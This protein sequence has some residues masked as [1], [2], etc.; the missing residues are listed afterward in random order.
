[1]ALYQP[2]NIFPSSFAGVGGGV[3][4]VTQPLTVSW[5]VNGSS[6]MTA[7]QIKIYENTTASKLVYNS[8]RVNL[9]H[10]FYGM[11]STGDVNY[12]QVTIPA[13]RLIN[14]SNG[15]SSGYK[16][17]IT[18]WWNGGSIQQLSPSFFLTRTNPAVTVSVPATVTSRSVTFTG[19]YTQAQGDTLDWFRWELALQDDPESPIEDSGYIYG[20][21]DIQVTY[22]G[23]F[24]NT[25][26][27]VRLTIQTENGVQ[28]TTGWQNFTAQYDVSDMKGYVDACVSPLEGVIIQWPRISY[29]NGKPSGPHQLTGGQLRLPAGSSITWDERNGEPMNI[30]T[31]WSLAWSGIVPL[32]GTSPVWRITGDGHT[33][34]LSIEP[35]LISL[36]LDGAV[37]ASVEIP[38]LLVDYTIRMVLT[39]R[40]LHMY[41]PVQEGGLYPSSV[42]F[43]SA[44]LYPMGGDV[45]WERFTYPLT[46]VQ[47]DIE[48]ITLYGEQRCDYIMVSGGEVSGALLGDLLTNFEFEPSWTLDTWFLATF[49]GTGINGGNITPSGDSITGAAVYRLKKGDRRLQLVANVGIGSSTLVDEGFRNQST[50]TYYVFVLGTNTYVSAPLISNPVT[51]M[52]WNWTVLDCS[53]DSNGTYH[54]EEAHLFRNSVSTDSISNNNAP[55]MLQN[56]TP[57]PL[58]QPSSYN[59]KSSTLT[60]YIGRVDMKL[61]QYI[62]TVDMAEALYNLSVSNNPKFLRDRKG[63]LWRIQT[64]AAVSMQTGDTMVPQPYFGSFPWAEVGAADGISII[65]QPGDGAWDSTTGQEPDSGETVTKIVVT[66]PF[67]STVTL[68]NGQESYTEVCYGYITYQPATPGDWT[69]TAMRDGSSA[70]ETITMAEGVTYYV[71]LVITEVYA[72]LII[73][74]PS[75]TVITVSQG[76]EFEETKVV[77]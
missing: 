42:L 15:F 44:T 56:F 70:S 36:I 50:Y 6:A 62:D 66:A 26:Y 45:S 10:P 73:A 72:T 63:N 22:D 39:P 11:T 41:Y 40:E 59:F 27:S 52:F 37:L 38:H 49:N 28:A 77:P 61:N 3:V 55:S 24:T 16:M 1:M 31:P 7:Y 64:N 75:G 46:W 57:Y 68:T 9:Q 53:V 5:Q 76:S 14:L 21:E 48:S 54:L 32:T 23:L 4:D 19:S 18:Q 71:G 47:P 33:L 51:P 13:N 34:S 43:P 60:G 74:A 2:T 69:V 8:D 29:I 58:R 20:T 17:L 65:C 25:A 12:F 35:H 30:P 67:G